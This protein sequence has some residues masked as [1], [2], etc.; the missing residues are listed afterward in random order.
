MADSENGRVLE[1]QR[2]DP[3]TGEPTT[4]PD[5]EWRRTWGWR[6]ARLQ[7]PRD[8]DRLPSGRTLVVDSHGDRVLEVVPNGSVVWNVTIGMP[9]DA[10]RL[11]TGDE[12]TDGRA[13]TTTGVGGSAGAD[14]SLAS[15]AVLALKS[16]VPNIVVNSLLYVSPSWVRFTDLLVAAILLL[17]LLV[18]GGLEL[19]WS[20]AGPGSLRGAVVGVVRR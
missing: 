4:G 12:S 14:R 15:R 3:E 19:R 16:A 2:V 18:W 13:I 7:W 10:E 5:G 17:D 6:D 8:A 9:Y 11:D 1:Y 20:S